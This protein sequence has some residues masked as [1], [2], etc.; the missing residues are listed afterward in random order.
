MPRP[1]VN[2]APLREMIAREARNFAH[3]AVDVFSGDVPSR[4]EIRSAG[5]AG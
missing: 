4:V 2:D 5:I 1:I 3:E